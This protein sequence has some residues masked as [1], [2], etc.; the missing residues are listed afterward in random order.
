M[1]VPKRGTLARS[2]TV[3]NSPMNPLKAPFTRLPPIGPGLRGTE[4]GG[5][6]GQ[7]QSRVPHSI[8]SFLE[9]QR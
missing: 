8:R 7:Q 6:G 5:G 1:I 9:N 2:N 4:S 3:D